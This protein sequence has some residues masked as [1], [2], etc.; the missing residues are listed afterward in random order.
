M[1]RTV[2]MSIVFVLVL[3]TSV[4]VHTPASFVFRYIP[5]VNGLEVN[6]VSG[7]IWNGVASDFRWQGQSLGAVN[8]EFNPLALLTGKADLGVR[9]SGVP[10]F[11]ARGNLGYGFSGV[12][13]SQLLIS[14]PAHFVQSFI[15]YPLPVSLKGQFDLTLRDY[16]LQQPFC[17]VLDGT[18]AWS[19]GSVDSPMGSVEPG[20]VMAQLTCDTGSVLVSGDSDSEALE[21]EF[22]LSLSPDQQYSVSGWFIPGDALPQGIKGQLGW[23][24]A[25]DGEGRYRL[26]FNG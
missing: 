18:L 14:A 22:N 2:L 7:T 23:L 4:V 1:K 25:P 11:S 15:P 9:V 8:W 17:D 12:Y 3:L 20:L 16:Q 19:Q 13:A 24:G 26:S 10:G 21:T 6:G 5:P